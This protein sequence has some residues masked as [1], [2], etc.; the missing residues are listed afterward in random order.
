MLG[1]GSTI[2]SAW[3]SA[4]RNLKSQSQNLSPSKNPDIL[5]E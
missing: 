2:E 3:E 1:E 4:A 5:V